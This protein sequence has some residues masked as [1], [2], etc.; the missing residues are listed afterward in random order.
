MNGKVFGGLSDRR[1]RGLLVGAE[2]DATKEIYEEFLFVSCLR[3]GSTTSV[4]GLGC[5]SF[6]FSVSSNTP[7]FVSLYP[8]FLRSY[9]TGWVWP[10][11]EE[12]YIRK[13]LSFIGR[14]IMLS[15]ARLLSDV[16]SLLCSEPHGMRDS[17]STSSI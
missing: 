6:G 10:M 16:H 14:K 8:R 13:G 11:R 12:E 2:C 5:F 3:S 9:S 4:V 7:T 17:F 15:S 1:A